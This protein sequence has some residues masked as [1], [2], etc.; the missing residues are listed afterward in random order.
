MNSGEF[1]TV[2]S[3]VIAEDISIMMMRLMMPADSDD[4]MMIG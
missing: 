4:R 1:A 3:Y 2:E